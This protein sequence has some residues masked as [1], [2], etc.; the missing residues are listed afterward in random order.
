MD[1][2]QEITKIIIIAFG[3]VILVKM[4]YTFIRYCKCKDT[5]E[6]KNYIVL[7]ILYATDMGGLGT[8]NNSLNAY[9][10]NPGTSKIEIAFWGMLVLSLGLFWLLYNL[11][12]FK[13]EIIH[14]NNKKANM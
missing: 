3:I 12:I 10:K 4:I 1:N 11:I 14:R 6:K 5:K 8:L 2:L 13:L 9:L 7:G